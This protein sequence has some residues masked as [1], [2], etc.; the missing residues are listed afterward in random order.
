MP[1]VGMNAGNIGKQVGTEVAR[2]AKAEG[3]DKDWSKVRVGSIED[4]QGRHLHAAATMARKTRSSPPCRLRQGQ[5]RLASP[6][7]TR[8]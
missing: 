8:W 3:W 7:T 1:Y 6:T 5:D 2:I 4:Q